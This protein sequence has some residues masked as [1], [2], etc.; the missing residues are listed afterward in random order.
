MQALKDRR[1]LIVSNRLPINIERRKDG[2]HFVPSIG[3]LATGLRA[4]AQ[5]SKS[6]WV[7]WPGIQPKNEEE[8]NKIVL[9]LEKNFNCLPLFI[10]PTDIKKYYSGFSNRAIWPLFHYFLQY[11]VYDPAE[12]ETYQKV[13]QLFCS[14]IVEIAR[15]NDVIWIHDYHLLLLP[16]LI[17]KQLPEATIG[18][19]L[20]I[21]FPPKEIFRSL[22]W[23]IEILKGL[24]GADLVGFHTYGYARNFLDSVLQ[25]CGLE[26]HF[27]RIELP[28]RPIQIDAFPLGVDTE[29]INTMA[30]SPAVEKE[31]T[32]IIKKTTGRKIIFS[33]DRLDYTKG[34]P[35]RLLAFEKFLEKYPNWR[36]K[37][38]FILLSAPSRISIAQY[39]FLKQKV[40]GLIGKINGKYGVPGW[41][42]IW[43]FYRS[44][45]LQ[46]LIS[47][48]QTADVAL[49][50]P[51]Q[52]GMNLVAKEYLVSRKDLTGVLILSKSAGASSELGEASLVNPNNTEEVADAINQALVLSRE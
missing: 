48:Y 1:L 25:L 52:D 36:G 40:D 12:W 10:P 7:G 42:P 15:P 22:P 38:T 8:K 30:N 3:G 14:K 49:I 18:F 29:Y 32:R 5:K 11:C 4:V 45:P 2:L 13:N 20:H 51:L 44:L 33:V 24:L 23:C 47:F 31:K 28:D 50:T 34:V 39:Q 9:E 6:V 16:E 43:Y 21:P 27:G 17:R 35:E 41:I 37:V 19:F 46:R 26:D